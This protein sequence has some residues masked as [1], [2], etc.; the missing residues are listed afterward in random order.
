[1]SLFTRWFGPRVRLPKDMSEALAA[2]RRLPPPDLDRPL[3]DLRWVVVDTESSGLDPHQDRL[4]SIG[5]CAIDHCKLHLDEVFAV[6]LRQHYPSA[7]DNILV[8]G[9]TGSA[10]LTGEE[11]ATAL[12]GFLQFLRNDIPVAFHAAFDATLLAHAMRMH[13]GAKLRR[14][15]FDAEW[16]LAA[17]FPDAAGTRRSLDDWLRRFGISGYTRHDALSDAFAT[18]E[19]LLIAIEQAG[20]QGARSARDLQRLCAAHRALV[21]LRR[22]RSP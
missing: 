10:Q 4:L 22:T 13:L 19:L 1:V 15:W 9:I 11:P 2:W 12:L 7:E 14:V 16:I 21:R 6:S 8:H 3:A 20:L 18:A 17:L 5:A